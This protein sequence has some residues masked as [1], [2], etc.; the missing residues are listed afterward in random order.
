MSEQGCRQVTEWQGDWANQFA[1]PLQVMMADAVVCIK[2]PYLQD[3]AHN[4]Q[5]AAVNAFPTL[6]KECPQERD[7]SSNVLPPPLDI[8]CYVSIGVMQIS[9]A[10]SG[11][12]S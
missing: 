11:C 4:V 9:F 6:P 2:A 12:M 1:P 8:G 5:C 3:A 7:E 10:H